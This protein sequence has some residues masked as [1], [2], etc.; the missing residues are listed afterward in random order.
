MTDKLLRNFRKGKGLRKVIKTPSFIL[1]WKGKQDAKKGDTI[2]ET[3]INKVKAKCRALESREVLKA[4][5]IL[6]PSRKE[7]AALM[8]SMRSGKNSLDTLPDK[9]SGNA[10]SDMLANRMAA[11]HR[12]STLGLVKENLE[13]LVQINELIV[14]VNT[15][16]EQRIFKMRHLCSERL[17]AYMIGVREVCPGFGEDITYDD[18]ANEVYQVK[19]LE[20]DTAI[21]NAVSGIYKGGTN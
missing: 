4:E 16:L 1:K 10:A 7:G 11:S 9:R 6:F 3:Y 13:K 12:T 15:C 20:C 5:E 17:E 19:H 21:K 14:N 8:A 18:T 2:A